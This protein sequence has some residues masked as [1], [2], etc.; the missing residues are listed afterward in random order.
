MIYAN[1]NTREV[2]SA[3]LDNIALLLAEQLP[4]TINRETVLELNRRIFAGIEVA[5]YT[6]GTFRPASDPGA[7]NIS[8]RNLPSQSNRQIFSMRSLVD[9]AALARF[10][11]ALTELTPNRLKPLS[12]S[13]F[14]A[15]ISAIYARL[16]YTHPFWDGNSRTFRTLM[17]KAAHEAGFD[18]NWNHIASSQAL[19]DAL[20]CARSIEANRLALKDPA[21]AHVRESVENMLEAL[22]DQ[23]SLSELLAQEEIVT[24]I[25]ALA[26]IKAIQESF[27]AASHEPMRF[28][29]HLSQA[30]RKLSIQYPE[31]TAALTQL[32]CFMEAKIS[33]DPRGYHTLLHLV[34]PA[35][36]RVIASGQTTITPEL[37]SQSVP[38]S[39]Q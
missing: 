37:L 28:Q 18:L 12:T 4:A 14:I 13:E 20:Y 5:G 9:E 22:S 21:Q 15:Q 32:T 23:R 31:I 1:L 11:Q 17:E 33:H 2:I 3:N 35:F 39:N 10:D 29:Q 38:T 19:R 30:C 25:R 26:L 34:L 24:P 6:P 8:S 36:Y 16:D 7:F 27:N